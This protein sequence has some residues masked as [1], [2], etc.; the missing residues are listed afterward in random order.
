MGHEY[1]FWS[2]GEKK[3]IRR[4][5]WKAVVPGSGKPIELYDVAADLG[6]TSDLSLQ[7]PAIV[8]EMHRIINDATQ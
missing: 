5:N 4:G 2:Y 1:L 7:H 6:E 8:E 3:A